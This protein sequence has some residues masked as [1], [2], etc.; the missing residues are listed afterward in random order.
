M[1]LLPSDCVCKACFQS[2]EKLLKVESSSSS[3][4][5]TLKDSI[6]ALALTQ[7]I[8]QQYTV[9]STREESEHANGPHLQRERLLIEDVQNL[10]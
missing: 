7:T 6:Q 1:E 9:W 4:L 10:N 5:D 8:M 2:V 3:I